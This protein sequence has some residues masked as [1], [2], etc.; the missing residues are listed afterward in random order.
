MATQKGY[1]VVLFERK[2]DETSPVRRVSGKYLNL[3]FRDG[4]SDRTTLQRARKYAANT[5]D[6]YYNDDQYS[7]LEL[8]WKTDEIPHPDTVEVP[9]DF[10]FP[11]YNEIRRELREVEG[12]DYKQYYSGVPKKEL[13]EK[14]YYVYVTYVRG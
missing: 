12:W 14:I 3:R 4:V 1:R 6:V 11:A 8:G 7:A 2:G 9:E 13:L 10:T 5:G